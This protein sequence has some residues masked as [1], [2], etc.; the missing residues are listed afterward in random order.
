[1][2]TKNQTG[3]SLLELPITSAANDDGISPPA[4]R[5]ILQPRKPAWNPK[6]VWRTRVKA[7]AKF[8]RG[9]PSPL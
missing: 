1:M 4:A 8:P 7:P 3:H 6:E 2:K 5:E 9:E